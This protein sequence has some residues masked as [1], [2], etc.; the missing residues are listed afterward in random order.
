MIKK[1]PKGIDKPDSS[2]ARVFLRTLI[3]MVVL[4]KKQKNQD[5][6]LQ[7][8]CKTVQGK[9]VQQYLYSS[10]KGW[11]RDTKNS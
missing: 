11:K 4:L 2:I 6:V 9:A 3:T 8:P 7:K 5:S 10:V 1:Q